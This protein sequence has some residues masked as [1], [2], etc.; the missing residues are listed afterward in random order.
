MVAKRPI[1]NS[2][3]NSLF[4][5]LAYGNDPALV[6]RFLEQ[7]ADSNCRDEN[8]D[9]LIWCFLCAL[10]WRFAPMGAEEQRRGLEALGDVFAAG[11]R[12]HPDLAG[13][14]RLRR[15]LAQSNRDLVRSILELL[16]RHDVLS[17]AELRELTRT[18]ALRRLVVPF[19]EILPDT[20]SQAAARAKRR[21][22]LISPTR[23][24][25]FWIRH[26]S[27]QEK[28]TKFPRP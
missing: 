7:G 14:R 11:A 8:G 12:W 15:L 21:N 13:L 2:E 24:T 19:A 23:K 28:F 6:R 22:Q 26:W 27:Q 3:L 1:P 25:G 20:P 17:A 18:P 16:N 9:P 4:P 5:Y 10:L